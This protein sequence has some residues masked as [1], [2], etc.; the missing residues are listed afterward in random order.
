MKRGQLLILAQRAVEMVPQSALPLLVED[1]LEAPLNLESTPAAPSLLEEVRSFHAQSMAG[2]FYEDFDVNSHTCGDQSNGT[3]AF[4]AEFDR[5]ASRC[6]R[7]AGAEPGQTVAQAFEV[8]FSL[9]RYIEECNDDVL[10]FADEGGA[11][12]VGVNWSKV[13]PAYF[14]C[15]ARFASAE[16]FAQR[17]FRIVV[18]FV[19]F[20]QQRYWAQASSVASEEQRTSLDALASRNDRKSSG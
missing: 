14:L 4:I 3:D 7:D 9:L 13:L 5:L 16:D 8:L 2:A 19:G 1:M 6:V 18:D 17:V 10:F 12:S 11:W 20:D 15:V